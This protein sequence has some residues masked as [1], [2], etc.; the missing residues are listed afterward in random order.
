MS[1]GET[2]LEYKG[3]LIVWKEAQ[4]RYERS[5]E[6]DGHTFFFDLGVS[7]PAWTRHTWAAS[8]GNPLDIVRPSTLDP[9]TLYPAFTV[10]FS[11]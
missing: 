2:I 5:A 8:G 9:E 10:S 1:A 4:R 7:T 6:E 11:L 3:E